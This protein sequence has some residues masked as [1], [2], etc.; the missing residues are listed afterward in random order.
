[1]TRRMTT[2]ELK[3]LTER[4]QPCNRHNHEHFVWLPKQQANTTH[5]VYCGDCGRWMGFG[6]KQQ[7]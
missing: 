3:A 4:V 7:D 2:A 1:M 5:T 6:N